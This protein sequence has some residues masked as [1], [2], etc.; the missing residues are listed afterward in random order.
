MQSANDLRQEL[1]II[2]EGGIREEQGQA[3]PSNSTSMNQ[4]SRVSWSTATSQ[5]YHTTYTY[6][7]LVCIYTLLRG[8]RASGYDKYKEYPSTIPPQ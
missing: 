8:V 7:A 3:M 6:L 4:Q 1:E 5:H 2:M